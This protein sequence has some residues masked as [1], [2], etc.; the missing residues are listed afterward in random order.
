MKVSSIE[1]KLGIC[2]SNRGVDTK[3]AG[4]FF[5]IPARSKNLK[6]VRSDASFLATDDFLFFL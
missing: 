3:E 6:K 5:S 1:R 2:F 4:F